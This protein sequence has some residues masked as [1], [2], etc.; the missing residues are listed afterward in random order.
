M[1]ES[2]TINVDGMVCAACQSHVQRA[3]DKTHGVAQAAVNLMT[4]QAVVR[5]DPQTVAPAALL[6]AIRDTG[7]EAE[8][9][10][11]GLTALEQQQEQDQ[12]Q[13][14]E[15]RELTRKAAIAFVLGMLVMFVPMLV[16]MLVPMLIQG[17]S[18]GMHNRAFQFGAAVSTLIVMVYCGGS[19]Y[20]AAWKVLRHGSADMNVLV[21]LG[22][23]VA[24]LYSFAVTFLPVFGM[25]TAGDVAG[26]DVY[27][28]AAILILAFVLA[29]RA[30]EAQAKRQTAGAL[31]KLIHLQPAIAHV[32]RDVGEVDL[33]LERV[34]KGDVI[35]VRPAEKIPVDGTVIEGSSY[36]D[37]SMLTGESLPVAKD[38]GKMVIG[39]TVN[40]TGSFRFEATAL[41]DASVLFRIVNL[42]RQA[43]GSRA[44]VE[45]L[46]DRISRIFVPT[47]LGLALLT[48][49][50][51]MLLD[52]HV[53]RAATA[54]VAVLIIA[55]PC[56]MG[57]AV[58]TAVMVATGRGAQMGLLIKGGAPLERLHLVDTVVLDKT[59]TLTEGRPRVT[60]VHLNDSS[61][62]LLAAAERTSQHPLARAV[63]EYAEAAGMAI[64]QASEFQSESGLG[65][66][67]MVEGHQVLSGNKTFL[68]ANGISLDGKATGAA[69]LVAIDGI[70][71]GSIDLQD[72]L[73]ESVP[74]TMAKLRQE[75][76]QI[77]LLSGDRRAVAEA[78]AK[79]C[80]IDTVI[81]EVLPEGKA[82]EIVRLKQKGQVVAM[83]GDGI[84]DAPA[85]AQADV[86]FAMGTGTDIAMEAGDVTLL[87][88]DL[89]GVVDAIQLARAT[90]K[91][92]RQNLGWALAYNVIAIP[93]AALGY[94]NPV[95][96]SAAMALSS[97][98]VVANS[99]RLR[100]FKPTFHS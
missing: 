82:S 29:G 25:G 54:A 58:P 76:M 55:C 72:P 43:Q 34:R 44:P 92:M 11:A 81:A 8:L 4:G 38:T 7:Y 52:G 94:L 83:V 65:I 87:R 75:G 14:A 69:V 89:R 33:P 78:V 3:L 86:G 18:M 23:G 66:R 99:L 12:S 77:I 17:T 95:I 6:E 13:T 20:S 22:T 16:A 45:R 37:E 31:R 30:L 88:G 35:V 60:G 49:A 15:V 47:V 61:L 10:R 24:A 68:A 39:G 90:W 97:I 59:G 2:V 28:E 74:G 93:A 98:S 19:I 36:V 48:F 91:I 42:M 41:G 96:A 46:A 53:I 63:V 62:R 32:I 56:A 27:Y 70:Y 1:T 26:A 9:P 51:W 21:A 84:N 85:L 79:Q 67:A 40:T 50:G 71:Q 73:R 5:F 64:P 100:R 57:L 80:G